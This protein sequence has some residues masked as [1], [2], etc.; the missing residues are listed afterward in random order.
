[1]VCLLRSCWDC[2]LMADACSCCWVSG[3]VA[4]VDDVCSFVFVVVWS[5]LGSRSLSLNL[6][7]RIDRISNSVLLTKSFARFS[8]FVGLAFVWILLMYL[9]VSLSFFS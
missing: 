6:S 1:M 8:R 2:W 9:F 7:F 3:G 5:L 4:V